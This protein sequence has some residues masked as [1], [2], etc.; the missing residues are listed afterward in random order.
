MTRPSTLRPTTSK[1]SCLQ[2]R[3]SNRSRAALLSPKATPGAW[4]TSTCKSDPNP[5]S[6]NSLQPRLSSNRHLL[7]HTQLVADCVRNK[8]IDSRLASKFPDNA[9]S[10]QSPAATPLDSELATPEPGSSPSQ[11]NTDATTQENVRTTAPTIVQGAKQPQQP[12]TRPPRLGRDG[13]PLRPRKDRNR[14][15]S[16]D[17]ARENLVMQVLSES[18][19]GLYEQPVD[20]PFAGA[21]SSANPTPNPNAGQDEEADERME[22]EFRRNF[23]AAQRERASR[24]PAPAPPGAKGDPPRGPKL[25]GSRSQR[26]AMH[27]SLEEKAAQGIKPGKK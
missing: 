21:S 25:G 1:L 23:V 2:P 19:L 6:A 24:R 10:A 27:R 13:K 9:A 16:S 18:R 17:I 15:T 8:Y 5:L 7:P 26:A 3:T 20:G 14:R 4:I 11:S 22:R 12:K